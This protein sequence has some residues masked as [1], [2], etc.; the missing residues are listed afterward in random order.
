MSNNYF[1]ID[2]GTTNSAVVAITEIAENN[3]SINKS[4]ES[5]KAPLPSF[6]AINKSTGE[7]RTGLTA[8]RNI[9]NS[10]EYITFS[11]VKSIIGEELSWNIAG[12]TWTPIDIAAELFKALKNNTAN[13]LN[14]DLSEAVLAV[15]IGF[16]SEKKNNLRKAASM[17]GIDIKMFISEP[18]AAFCSRAHELGKFKNIAVFDWG[19]GTL[20]VVVIR[21]DGTKINELATTGINL[22]GN[23]I[24]KKIAEKICLKMSRKI[25]QDFTFDDLSS[26]AQ[27]TLLRECETAKCALADE[28]FA[29]VRSMSSL[30]N[31]GRPNE[32][33][34]YDFFSV[35]IENEVNIAY[36]CLIKALSEAGMNKESID[37]ILC[38]GG[39]SRLRPFQ[40]KLLA[41]FD[42]EKVIFPHDAMWDI[43]GGASQ[44]S[45]R[46][47]CYTLNKPIGI[48]LSN[49]KF[50][51]LLNIGQ[52]LPTQEKKITLGVTESNEKGTPEAM[53]VLTDAENEYEQ[54]FLEYFPVKLRGF[55][56][57][58]LQVNCYIDSD[59]VFKMKVSSNRTP[60]RY[61]RVWT[62][63]QIK[64]SYDIEGDN[65]DAKYEK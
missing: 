13:K 17:A 32:Q 54:S 10:D 21:V 57:E 60:D 5:E 27:L 38:V 8:K 16:S 11:S 20:D 51:P 64:I 50:F 12:K 31:Y 19:G 41:T 47:G 26:K 24:D 48:L 35:L 30:D 25:N 4:G 65:T 2:F 33:I 44:V 62:Y 58:V 14:F 9:S 61:F 6:V 36:E 52:R 63:N 55:S 7:V 29:T 46:P 34:D 1:G 22:A 23:D 37:C 42:R 18:T 49:N 40:E 15:P 56:D 53:F 43:A 39:S 28:D 3:F 59:L 45:Y